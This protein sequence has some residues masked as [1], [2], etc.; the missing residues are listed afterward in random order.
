MNQT[1]QVITRITSKYGKN[2]S[3]LISVLQDV[4]A[5][6]NYLPEGSLDI[7]SAQLAVPLSTV[8][9]VATFFKAFSFAPRGRHVA[10]LCTGT[11]CHVRGAS[12]LLVEAE[13]RLGISPGE[14]TADQRFT[15]ETVNCLGCC[16]VGPLLVLDGKYHG[17][18]TAQRIAGVLEGG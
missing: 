14:T 11:A 7:V 16:A 2:R 1:Q 6:Y 12:T 13:T 3:A 5:A 15:L 10:T 17:Q 8:Y 9:G 4:H 18:M